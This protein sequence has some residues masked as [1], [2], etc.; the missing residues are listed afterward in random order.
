[1][2]S[3]PDRFQVEVLPLAQQDVNQAL[4]YIAADDPDAADRL[5]DG[6]QRALEQLQLF[7]LS[8]V[9]VLIGGRRPR[10]YHRLYVHPYCIFYRVY[11]DRIV[12]MRVLRKRMDTNR[13][14]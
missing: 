1:M 3:T 6:I 7:P 5:F 11:S 13:H 8:G 2:S 4:V 12:V 10:R 9:E 14:L